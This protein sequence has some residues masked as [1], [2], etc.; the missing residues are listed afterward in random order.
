MPLHLVKINTDCSEEI[1]R[2]ISYR[3]DHAF[4]KM[5]T[6]YL[7]TPSKYQINDCCKLYMFE[8]SL[9]FYGLIKSMKFKTCG[10]YESSYYEYTLETASISEDP[11]DADA[12]KYKNRIFN[13]M[14]KIYMPNGSTR[15]VNANYNMVL[16]DRMLAMSQEVNR[17]ENY[18]LQLMINNNAIIWNIQSIPIHWYADTNAFSELNMQQHWLRDDICILSSNL[19]ENERYLHDIGNDCVV[20]V[21]KITGIMQVAHRQEININENWIIDISTLGA[22]SNYTDIKLTLK[23][24][25]V[26]KTWG[27]DTQYEIGEYILCPVPVNEIITNTARDRPNAKHLTLQLKKCISNHISS[28]D[29]HSNQDC[30]E[31]VSQEFCESESLLYEDIWQKTWLHIAELLPFYLTCKYSPRI[32]KVKLRV[33]EFGHLMLLDIIQFQDNNCQY[34]IME[35]RLYCDRNM[36]YVE[37]I[38]HMIVKN[39]LQYDGDDELLASLAVANVSVLK[40]EQEANLISTSDVSIEVNVPNAQDYY[41]H[42]ATPDNQCEINR[43]CTLKIGI[44]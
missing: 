32:V 17:A 20:N 23:I 3:M 33:E 6:L 26:F 10:P 15:D 8:D 36:R 5:P 19:H 24:E 1:V 7:S 38:A 11:Q 34:Q 21:S 18:K 44:R 14:T 13:I 29:M 35:C 4:G 43:I 37:I 12:E 16:L 25:D 41:C 39:F 31:N 42:I 28:D 22:D 9:L 2:S 40:F 30:W 27:A